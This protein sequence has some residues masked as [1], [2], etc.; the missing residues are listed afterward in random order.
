[1]TRHGTLFAADR[2]KSLLPSSSEQT[3]SRA[4]LFANPKSQSSRRWT[5][6]MLTIIIPPVSLGG[7]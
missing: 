6:G 4:K 5:S 3:R 1:M 2:G 7:E